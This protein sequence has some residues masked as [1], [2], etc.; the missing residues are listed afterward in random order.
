MSCTL[1]LENYARHF[2]DVVFVHLRYQIPHKTT[3]QEVQSRVPDRIE[4]PH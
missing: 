1:F 4:S 3:I 2:Q